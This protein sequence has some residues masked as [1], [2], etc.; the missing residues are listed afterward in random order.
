MGA[1]A[2]IARDAQTGRILRGCL[3]I[4]TT[5]GGRTTGC[6]NSPRRRTVEQTPRSGGGA[7][8][9]GRAKGRAGCR[10]APLDGILAEFLPLPASSLDR[11]IAPGRA[12]DPDALLPPP[13]T[14][15]L[16]CLV[17]PTRHGARPPSAKPPLWPR[18]LP[19]DEDMFVEKLTFRLGWFQSPPGVAHPHPCLCQFFF[20]LYSIMISA[21]ICTF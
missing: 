13:N 1:E 16:R 3:G 6:K 17:L 11:P 19:A 18:L 2:A 5:F 4:S 14:Q 9:R 15:L 7:R 20:F 10:W 8:R 21:V 12:R